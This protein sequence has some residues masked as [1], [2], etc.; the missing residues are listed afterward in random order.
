[1]IVGLGYSF[2]DCYPKV[3]CPSVRGMYCQVT[4]GHLLAN[5][6]MKRWSTSL[7]IRKMQIKTAMKYHL[8]P[9]RIGHHQ[10]I[11]KQMLERVFR[12]GNPHALLVGV[13]IDTVTMEI[14]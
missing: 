9:I 12:K 6:H 11:Y 14:P 5:K 3:L 4:I 8:T 7:I 10:K 1:M 13:L 2:V